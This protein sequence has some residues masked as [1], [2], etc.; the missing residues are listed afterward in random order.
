MNNKA[1]KFDNVVCRKLGSLAVY[2]PPTPIRAPANKRSLTF[3][4]RFL[5]SVTFFLYI[6]HLSGSGTF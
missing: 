1:K 2:S 3:E 5:H 4:V 6:L